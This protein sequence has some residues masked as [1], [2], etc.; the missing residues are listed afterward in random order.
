M[1]IEGL[2]KLV[3]I[4]ASINT[5]L[6]PKL[7]STFPNLTAVS[8]PLVQS[9]IINDPYWVA[10]FVNAEGCFSIDI[11]KSK[12]NKLGHQVR[13]RLRIAQHIRDK[14]LME[15]LVKYL[16]CGVIELDS[17]GNAVTF[18]VSKFFDLESK[19]LPFFNKYQMEGVKALNFSDFCPP[20][21]TDR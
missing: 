3:A 20:P 8:R 13:I 11:V 7:T 16:D 2:N 14:V 6:S 21:H 1:T 9:Q 10:G 19:I 15:S 12:G 18:S 17:R 5:G 4:K